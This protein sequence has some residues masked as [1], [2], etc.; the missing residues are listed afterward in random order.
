MKKPGF[1]QSIGSL[2]TSWTNGS[3]RPWGSAQPRC[4]LGAGLCHPSGAVA[5]LLSSLRSFFQQVCLCASASSVTREPSPT[6]MVLA[7]GAFAGALKGKETVPKDPTALP[8]E[9]WLVANVPT[10]KQP[11]WGQALRAVDAR[12]LAGSSKTAA[13]CLSGS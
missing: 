5:C 9:Q 2:G 4:P 10:S 11:W 1:T 7:P 6:S 13:S 8:E 3:P 12:D